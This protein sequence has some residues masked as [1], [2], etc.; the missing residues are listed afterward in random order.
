MI[1]EWKKQG[2]TVYRLSEA[3]QTA[4]MKGIAPLGDQLLGK[5]ENPQVR[6]MYGLLKAAAAK[7]M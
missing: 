7:N 3:D 4:Y 5:H 6:E 1:V 2:A